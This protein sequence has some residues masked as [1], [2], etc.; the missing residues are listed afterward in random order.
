MIRQNGSLFTTPTQSNPCSAMGT[1]ILVFILTADV[2][3]LTA[4]P[5]QELAVHRFL[6]SLVEPRG[7]PEGT[8]TFSF[9]SSSSV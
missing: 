9:P 4:N 7:N 5:L 8:G 2:F 6:S 3:N 1:C